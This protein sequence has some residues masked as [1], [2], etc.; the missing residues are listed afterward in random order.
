MILAL[1]AS[2]ALILLGLQPA[3]AAPTYTPSDGTL[4]TTFNV[5]GAGFGGNTVELIEQS[6]GKIIVVGMFTTY[7]GVAAGRIIRLN[8]DGTRDASFDTGTGFN[9][10]A[11]VIVPLSDGSIIVGGA[12]AT[13]NGVSTPSRLVKLSATGALDPN[14]HT[15][16]G[17]LDGT[18][19]TV[20]LLADGSLVAGGQFS[21]RI[22]KFAQDG[23]VDSTFNTAIG[24]G[25]TISPSTSTIPGVFDIVQQADGSLIVSGL[26]NNLNGTAI[27]ANITRLNLNGTRTT[28][29]GT[30]NANLSTGFDGG[31]FTIAQSADGKLIIAG[32]FTSFN[33]SSANRIIRLNADGTIDSSYLTGTGLNKNVEH[34]RLAPDGDLMVSLQADSGTYDGDAVTGVLRLNSDGTLDETFSAPVVSFKA[35]PTSSGAVYVLGYFTSYKGV[36]VGRFMRLTNVSTPE[37]TSSTSSQP[38]SVRTAPDELAQTGSGVEGLPALAAG[39]AIAGITALTLVRRSR[40]TASA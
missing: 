33:G 6:D 19:T 21:K 25:L 30:F 23:T 8:P 18:V 38:T 34:V 15:N 27:P 3:Q 39:L 40:R 35:I 13:F 29:A 37:P 22:L 11:Q 20:E 26:F 17:T 14:F 24:S 4:D 31:A 16:I 36:T 9:S 28:T 32:H 10:T 1:A 2:A 5:G 12:F 7:N